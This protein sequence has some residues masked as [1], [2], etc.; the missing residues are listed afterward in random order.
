MKN[1]YRILGMSLAVIS[2]LFVGSYL[3]LLQPRL[4]NPFL[5]RVRPMELAPNYRVGGNQAMML[6]QPIARIDQNL[7]PNR[8]QR[9][10]LPMNPMSRSDLE[11]IHQRA[12]QDTEEFWQGRI[13][14]IQVGMSR[15]KAEEIIWQDVHWGLNT[16]GGTSTGGGMGISYQVSRD[17]SV[18]V[19]YDSHNL[20]QSKPI[21]EKNQ[22]N[23]DAEQIDKAITVAKKALKKGQISYGTPPTVTAEGNCWVV[24]FLAPYTPSPPPGFTE[25]GPGPV[26]VFVCVKTLKVKMILMEPD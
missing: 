5:S 23:P 22:K 8:W 15:V 24:T 9:K 19:Y 14:G 7:F 11:K 17:W 21:L 2:F 3:I 16:W 26:K 1:L 20:V 25:I 4:R 10:S 13:E 18:G 6:Y 12:K